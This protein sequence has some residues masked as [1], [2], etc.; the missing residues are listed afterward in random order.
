MRATVGHVAVGKLDGE[1]KAEVGAGEAKLVFAD[2]VEEAGAVAEDDGNAGDGIPD[3]VAEAAQAGEGGVDLVPV[4][5]EGDV[6]RGADGEQALGVDG[7]GAGVGDVELQG[8]AGGEGL[9]ESDGGFVELA[10]VVG[11]GVEG[12]DGKGDVVE[13]D[14]DAL[15]VE[16]GGDLQ[17]NVGEGGL[18]SLRTVRRARTAR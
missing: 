1:A 11:V 4:G 15:P 10:G 16:R 9:G 7:D 17:G 13:V 6:V 5:V 3:D 2:F 8:G 12:G 14:A 18:L